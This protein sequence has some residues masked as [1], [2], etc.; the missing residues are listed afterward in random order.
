MIRFC[1]FILSGCSDMCK[2]L[3]VFAE[4]IKKFLSQIDTRAVLICDT[5]AFAQLFSKSA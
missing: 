4:V 3:S 5:E 1:R 2:E